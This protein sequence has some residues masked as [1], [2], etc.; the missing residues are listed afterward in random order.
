MRS[1]WREASTDVSTTSSRAEG[2]ASRDR[3]Q[4]R[5]GGPKGTGVGAYPPLAARRGILD[6][7]TLFQGNE[8]WVAAQRCERRVDFQP[9]D[10]LRALLVQLL[11]PRDR[12]VFLTERRVDAREKKRQRVRRALGVD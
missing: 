10:R 11:E 2:S 6:P 7:D 5:R 1:V 3:R 9:D 12:F 4:M 8:S